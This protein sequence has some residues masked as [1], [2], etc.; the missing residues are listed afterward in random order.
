[1]DPFSF[2]EEVARAWLTEL[3]VAYEVDASFGG[4]VSEYSTDSPPIGMAWDPRQP[5]E[6]DGVS[7]LVKAAQTAGVIGNPGETTI[8]FE[9][10]DDGDEGVYRWLLDIVDPSPLKV[11]T[12]S[13]AM[14]VLGEPDL[15]RAG[16]EAAVAV[17]R[18]A[19]QA[20]N[21]LAHQ[22]SDYIEA[23]IERG[24]N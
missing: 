19:V 9:F 14:A 13:E 1:M 17:L 24:G 20:A 23:S 2:H 10:V 12:L 7:L 6:E 18:E 8:T 15:N 3:V 5:G 4:D 16:I 11:A 21:H 22:L